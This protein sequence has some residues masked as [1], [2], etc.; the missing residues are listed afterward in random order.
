MIG[1]SVMKVLNEGAIWQL[2]L[3]KQMLKLL[4]Q[5]TRNRDYLKNNGTFMEKE[6]VIL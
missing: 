3:S 5:K 2:Q 6:R 4:L 1:A